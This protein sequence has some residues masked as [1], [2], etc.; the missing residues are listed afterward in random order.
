MALKC[1]ECSNVL[2]D[3]PDEGYT[4]KR[5]HEVTCDA[6]KEEKHFVSQ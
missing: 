4:P 1:Y 5:E 2:Q 6:T 3:C